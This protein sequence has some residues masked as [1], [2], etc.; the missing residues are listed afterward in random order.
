[1]QRCAN[2]RRRSRRAPKAP[3]LAHRTVPPKRSWKDFFRWSFCVRIARFSSTRKK[4]S[5]IIRRYIRYVDIG[6]GRPAAERD[7]RT[8]LRWRHPKRAPRRARTSPLTGTTGDL[9]YGPRP[10]A[11]PRVKRHLDLVTENPRSRHLTPTCRRSAFLR[12]RRPS[13]R[14]P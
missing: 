9:P 12:A 4:V 3:L 11:K 14:G 13:G 8:R 2:A 5:M 10:P 7:R 1:M 6:G